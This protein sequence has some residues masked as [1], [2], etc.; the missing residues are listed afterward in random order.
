[1]KIGILLFE[2]FHGRKNI[3]SSRIRGHW[4]TKHWPEAEIY[5]MGAKYDVV[6][7]QK[8]YWVEHAQ[9]FK[10]IKI[11]DMCDADF[12]H[13]GY[14]IKQMVDLCDAV[15]TSTVPLAEYMVRLTDKPVWCIPDRLDLGGFGDLKKKHKGETKKAVWFGYSENFPMLNSAIKSLVGLKFEEL[16]VIADKRKPYMMPVGLRDK[17]GLVNLP[18]TPETVNQ[19]IM[20]GDVVVNPTSQVGRWKYKSN[21][22]TITAW[23][24]GMPVAHNKDELKMLMTEESRRA[25]GERRYK[26]VREKYDIRQSVEEFK[27]LIEELYAG[28]SGG[29]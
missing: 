18:W 3:G 11:L 21:N 2:Q 19:D 14:R 13:W 1:M 28:H 27:K 6:I 8:V 16:I 9:M 20:S 17:I 10:G 4:L 22:K 26:E 23:A 12:K 7:Y 25:E 24:L 29:N 15:T 5:K